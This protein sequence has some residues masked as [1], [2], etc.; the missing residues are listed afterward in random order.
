CVTSRCARYITSITFA[1]VIRTL[2]VEFDCLQMNRAVPKTETV[3][4]ASANTKLSLDELAIFGGAPA[5]PKSLHV[6]RPN[7]GNRQKFHERVA[8]ILERKW[9]TN[10]GRYVDEF[11]R[12]IKDLCD[13]EHCVAM[14]NGTVALE[15]AIRALGMTGE[16]IV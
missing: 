8:D 15:I 1:V 16:V 5:F 11:E 3:E 10:G 6:G 12:R 7:I 9:I 2:R 13:V 4:I 14:C